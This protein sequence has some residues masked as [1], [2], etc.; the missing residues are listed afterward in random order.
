MGSFGGIDMLR[1]MTPDDYSSLYAL[2]LCCAGMGLNSVDDTE[3]SITRFLLR[4]PDTCFVYEEEGT[5]LG[6]ILAGNDGRRSYI[7]H[8]AVHPD[9]RRQGIGR[10][11][12]E[13]SEQALK[14]LGLSK[15]GLFVYDTNPSGNAFWEKQGYTVRTDIVYRNKILA[16]NLVTIKVK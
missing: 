11:L 12:L 13:A 4:N 8:A 9:H 1:L 10:Q 15:C 3:D 14:D 16:E 7:Y 2:W 6:A 5:I